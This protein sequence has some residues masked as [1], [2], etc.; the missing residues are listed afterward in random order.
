MKPDRD[1]DV[2]AWQAPS[3]HRQYGVDQ[4]ELDLFSSEGAP[5]PADH[6][7]DGRPDCIDTPGGMP[8]LYPRRMPQLRLACPS[9]DGEKRSRPPLWRSYKPLDE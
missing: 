8:R 6:R 2:P 1:T 4:V 7:S 3:F 5:S 9:P